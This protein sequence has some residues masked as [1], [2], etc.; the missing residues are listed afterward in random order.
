MLMQAN[1]T[2]N[3]KACATMA[4]QKCARMASQ[5]FSV[6]EVACRIEF[7]VGFGVFCCYCSSVFSFI[8]LVFVTPQNID[9]QDSIT[10]PGKKFTGTQVYHNNR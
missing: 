7:Y 5:V 2:Q 1:Q 9:A 6:V 10:N 4:P 3:N 8:V